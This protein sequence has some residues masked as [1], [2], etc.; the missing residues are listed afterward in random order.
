MRF[1]KTSPPINSGGVFHIPLAAER[2]VERG[3]FAAR[4]EEAKGYPP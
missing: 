3:P 1:G 4:A 2:H